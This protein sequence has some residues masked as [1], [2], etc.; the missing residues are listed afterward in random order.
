MRIK[1]FNTEEELKS[2]LKL[3]LKEIETTIISDLN[4]KQAKLLTYWLND[5]N[6]KFLTKEENFDPKQL[7]K[8][9]RGNIVNVHLG[10]NVGSEQGGL[11]YGLVMDVFNSKSTSIITIVPLRSL[12]DGEDPKNLDEKYEVYLGKALLKEKIEYVELE[13][14]KSEEKINNLEKEIIELKENNKKS[15]N[16]KEEECIQLRK[17]VKNHNKE[18]KNL[19]KGSVALVAQ[20][21]TISKL[22]IYEPTKSYHSLAKFILD[23]DNMKKVEDA[24]INLY[25][26]K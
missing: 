5:W 21:R 13:K 26:K 14:K 15:I 23:D 25:F 20:I 8:Y 6:E 12:K 10:Y 19:N 18:L 4:L 1:N 9:K 7:I 24:L 2:T 3:V 11:H 17:K 22:R 16:K